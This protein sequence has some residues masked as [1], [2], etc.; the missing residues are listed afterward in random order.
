MGNTSGISQQAA[1]VSWDDNH[2][3]AGLSQM[4]SYLIVRLE[5]QY[6]HIVFHM[7][8]T[9]A[10]ASHMPGGK[11]GKK[12]TA[13]DTEGKLETRLKNTQLY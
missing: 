2:H 5:M 1:A 12:Q 3:L 4:V 11:K 9:S 7:T 8:V 13:Q 10:G 6:L